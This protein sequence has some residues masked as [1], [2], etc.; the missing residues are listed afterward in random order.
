M[1]PSI[2]TVAEENIP[3]VIEFLNAKD[4]LESFMAENASIFAT[5]RELSER[6]NSTLEA[7][8]KTCRSAKVKCGPFELYA[9]AEKYDAEGLYNAIGRDKFLEVGGRIE[10]VPK[11]SVDSK[12]LEASIAKNLIP[13]DVVEQVHKVTPNYHKPDPVKLP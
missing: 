13:E 8:D 9:F 7:A 10:Q 5:F 2:K 1:K 4:A 6:Y 3:E 12:R 11:Y